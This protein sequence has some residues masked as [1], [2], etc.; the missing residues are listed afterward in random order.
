[1]ASKFDISGGFAYG[2]IIAGI[3][4]LLTGILGFMTGKFKKAIF[5][6]P[7]IILCLIL[8]ILLIIAGAIMAGD[9]SF[10]EEGLNTACDY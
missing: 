8:F 1:M 10:L 6:L 9:K 4:A 5:T 2:T 7:F 3:L